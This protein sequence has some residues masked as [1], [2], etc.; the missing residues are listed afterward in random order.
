[1]QRSS[2]QH[3]DTIKIEPDI[4]LLLE[5][6]EPD[7]GGTLLLQR[8][9]ISQNKGVEIETGYSHDA[10]FQRRRIPRKEVPQHVFNDA[11]DWI[12]QQMKCTP[13][14]K[15]LEILNGFR[16]AISAM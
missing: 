9:Y 1:M 4:T 15:L 14:G 12:A 16:K 6:S 11:L 5:Y 10:N 3:L 8:F 7:Q 2:D 13:S